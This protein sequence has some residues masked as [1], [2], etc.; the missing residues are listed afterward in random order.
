MP[1]SLSKFSAPQSPH[2]IHSAEQP[3]PLQLLLQKSN[4]PIVVSRALPKVATVVLLSAAAASMG[5]RAPDSHSGE[6]WSGEALNVLGVS[7]WKVTAA[8]AGWYVD[9]GGGGGGEDDLSEKLLYFTPRDLPL[10]IKICTYV[11]RNCT[12][13]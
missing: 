8:A 5:G 11:T 4:L 6:N 13:V 1:L 2:L 7:C 3:P 9:G 12:C 10:C